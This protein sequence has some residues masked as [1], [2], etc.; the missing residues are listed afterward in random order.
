MN[1][2]SS[3]TVFLDYPDLNTAFIHQSPSM[4]KCMLTGFMDRYN[5][6]ILETAHIK[7]KFRC[8]EQEKSVPFNQFTLC[9]HV[10]RLYD[11]RLV[12]FDPYTG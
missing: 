12:N 4:N 8:S 5:R 10:H 11:A 9:C 6:R 3:F 7:S 1:L 2:K